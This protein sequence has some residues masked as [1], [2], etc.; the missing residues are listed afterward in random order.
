MFRNPIF[1]TLA[2]GAP[3]RAWLM[4]TAL[5]A[6]LVTAAQTAAQS[7]EWT[8]HDHRTHFQ[9]DTAVYDETRQRFVV[10]ASLEWDGT[11]LATS[12]D[13]GPLGAAMAYDANRRETVAFGSTGAM[14]NDTRTFDGTV[15]TLRQPSTRPPLRNSLSTTMAYDAARQRVVLFGGAG[16]GGNLLR[17]TWEWDGSNWTQIQ[18][19]SSPSPRAGHTM[20]YDPTMRR[21]L[22]YGGYDARG[23]WYS[24]TWEWDGTDW[25]ERTSPR[26]PKL[27]VKRGSMSFDRRSGEILLFGT[28]QSNDTNALWAYKAGA[29]RKH[30]PK[31]RPDPW[32]W[33]L[34]FDHRRQRT[35]LFGERT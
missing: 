32:N 26:S 7:L 23:A 9:V 4:A 24:D 16:S 1:V 19:P 17:D 29:W 33:V 21:V 34:G 3:L 10:N 5:A 30:A 18:P 22:L 27:V 20:A 15:W 12:Q 11:T 2:R 31:N 28:S 8:R 25:T 6:T 13:Q 35:T 14:S